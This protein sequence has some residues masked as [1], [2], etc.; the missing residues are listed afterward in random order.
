MVRSGIIIHRRDFSFGRTRPRRVEKSTKPLTRVL[1]RRFGPLLARVRKGFHSVEI[2]RQWRWRK[3]G[4]GLF[5]PPAFQRGSEMFGGEYPSADGSSTSS[6]DWVTPPP[7]TAVRARS[8]LPP[9]P[10]P[11]VLWCSAGVGSGEKRA[12]PGRRRNERNLET[13]RRAIVGAIR[14]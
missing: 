12:Q 5:C 1:E 11:Q 4:V 6:I 9:P 2:W 14:R 10:S 7:L 8:D 3:V 13:L